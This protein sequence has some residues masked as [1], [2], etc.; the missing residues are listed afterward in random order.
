M[1][2]SALSCPFYFVGFFWFRISDFFQLLLCLCLLTLPPSQGSE[3]QAPKNMFGRFTIGVS[4][5]ALSLLL[6]LALTHGL[7]TASQT[8]NRRHNEEEGEIAL[9]KGLRKLNLKLNNA[10]LEAAQGSKLLTRFDSFYETKSMN[11][12]ILRRDGLRLVTQS[13]ITSHPTAQSQKYLRLTESTVVCRNFDSSPVDAKVHADPGGNEKDALR[14][15]RTEMKLNFPVP[16]AADIRW[17]PGMVKKPLPEELT[18]LQQKATNVGRLPLEQAAIHCGGTDDFYCLLSYVDQYELYGKDYYDSYST[19]VSNECANVY[20]APLIARLNKGRRFVCEDSDKSIKARGVKDDSEESYHKAPIPHGNIVCDA[21]LAHATHEIPT[22]VCEGTN[23]GVRYD[24]MGDGDYPWLNFRK[25]ALVA[26]CRDRN[27]AI[28]RGGPLRFMHCLADWLELGYSPL[29]SEGEAMSKR[30]VCDHTIHTPTYFL[31]RSGD[32]S[33]F[34]AIHDLLNSFIVYTTHQLKPSEMQLVVMDRMGMGFYTPMF[35]L[36]FAPKQKVLWFPDLREEYK[37]EETVCYRSAHFNIPARLSPIYNHDECK[38]S[39]L[40]RLFSDLILNATGNL[41]ISSASNTIVVTV[42]ARKN[43][44]TGHAIGR[45]IGNHEEFMSALRNRLWQHALIEHEEK[46]TPSIVVNSIDYALYNFDQQVA[47]SRATDVLVGMHGAGLVQA[48]FMGGAAPSLTTD[49]R[50]DY[51][52]GAGGVFEF[53]CPEKP[54]SNYRYGQLSN[55]LGLIYD[56]YEIGNYK[57]LVPI[58]EVLPMIGG[59]VH[60]VWKRKSHRYV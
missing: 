27:Q 13:R 58:D 59:L 17:R 54:S 45:R 43:Y 34:A 4:I 9:L 46:G 49:T 60:Q 8:Y 42:I 23:V 31:T 22:A 52:M 25:G 30:V 51:T 12:N 36:L 1:S 11:Q 21:T 2:F 14:A 37:K 48:L 29:Q 15:R 28:E 38:G 24:H 19:S 53:F 26:N 40:M 56:S 18:C 16:S 50:D 57:N 44:G 5:L 41:H 33:P 39:V 10:L 47:I 55:K 32:F 7:S 35:Q 6:L 20:G 3:C